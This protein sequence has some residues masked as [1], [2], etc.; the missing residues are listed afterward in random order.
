MTSC[1]SLPPQ[2]YT[3]PPHSHSHYANMNS[4]SHLPHHPRYNILLLV[5]VSS[6]S[7]VFAIYCSFL[8]AAS[9]WHLSSRKDFCS[10]C[11]VVFGCSAQNAFSQYNC[12]FSFYSFSFSFCFGHRLLIQAMIL[13]WCERW[14]S[15]DSSWPKQCQ[16]PGFHRHTCCEE[17]SFLD[18]HL[19]GDF[20]EE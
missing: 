16:I 11:L 9:F 2:C 7:Y 14:T 8:S 1:P 13:V 5:A 15:R 17:I 10:F 3:P 6:F 12:P 4:H 19:C 18:V 20:W